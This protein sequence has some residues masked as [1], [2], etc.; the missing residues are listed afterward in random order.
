MNENV[1]IS[2]IVVT[3]NQEATIGRA[4]DSILAQ[5]VDVPFEIVI[6]DD[7]S[8]DGTESVC[9]DYAAR[10]P[11]IIRYIRRER[12]LGV[13]GNYFNCIEQARGRY[14]ADCAGDDYWVDPLKLQMEYDELRQNT[15]VTLVHTDWRC[16]DEE[17][18]EIYEDPK[19]KALKRDSRSLSGKGELASGV[20]AHDGRAMVH[21]C[22]A[23]YRRDVILRE[24]RKNP[25]LFVDKDYRCEDLQLIAA[26]AAVGKIL[27]LPKVTLHYSVGKESLSHSANPAKTAR[28][29]MS[30]LNIARSVA[31]YYNIETEAVKR[32]YTET[33]EYIYA[34]IFLSGSRDLLKEFRNLLRKLELS[35]RFS[36]K[37]ALRRLLMKNRLL[38]RIARQLHKG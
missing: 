12:N 21:L 17:S 13:S 5:K 27:Y 36:P 34:Q 6:G 38:W 11:N 25:H 4:L 33:I 29:Y 26:M 30:N 9:R 37:G 18:G 32:Y 28:Q 22:S 24:Y 2:V 35:P 14:I 31:A 19:M 16:V 3:F 1:E 10:F 8:S 23:M 20:I 15:E 7:A